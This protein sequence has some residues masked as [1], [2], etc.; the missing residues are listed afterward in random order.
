MKSLVVAKLVMVLV[1]IHNLAVLAGIGGIDGSFFFN[2]NNHVGI[3]GMGGGGFVQ[4]QKHVYFFGAPED[5]HRS[6]FR[7]NVVPNSQRN[8]KIIFVKALTYESVT[9]EVIGPPS[10][11][12]DKTLVYV[13][14][15][16]PENDEQVTIPAGIGVKPSKP[17]VYF[18]KYKTQHMLISRSLMVSNNNK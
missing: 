5:K 10:L 14:V 9:P 8:I 4:D 7:I 15:K 2:Q 18:I 13:L 1:I 17:E 12:K 6:C 16:R 11:S 3:G